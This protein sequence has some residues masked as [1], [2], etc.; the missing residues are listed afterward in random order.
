MT[1]CVFSEACFRLGIDFNS[2]APGSDLQHNE[3]LIKY[4]NHLYLSWVNG[5]IIDLK[6]GK[7]S[8]DSLGGKRCWHT[9]F[10]FSN[11]ILL[12]GLPAKLKAKDIREGF[13]KTFGCGSITSVHHLDETAAFV[14][15]SRAELV[16]DFL[17]LKD[18]LEKDNNNPISVLHP[19]SRILDTGC[20]RAA[21][22]EA[23]KEVCRSP[24]SEVL[25][26]VQAERIGT[27]GEAGLVQSCGDVD[28]ED[29]C[30]REGE[31]TS[32]AF[33]AYCNPKQSSASVRSSAA[34]RRSS[35]NLQTDQLMDSL[36]RPVAQLSR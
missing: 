11:M 12:W 9:K 33:H 3:K 23:Y 35:S 27:K 13:Y 7:S 36:C 18:S 17:E 5:N 20:V 1:G 28:G 10:T 26:A 29:D 31:T 4:I 21:T 22:Y 25:F 6:S 32:T 15:F 16:S 30:E 14:Q 19:L 34:G 24:L 8:A 2:H